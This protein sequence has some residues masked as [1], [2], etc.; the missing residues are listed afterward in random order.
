MDRYYVATDLKGALDLTDG[1]AREKVQGSLQ[2]TEG[3]AMDA[4]TH[5]PKIEYKLLDG[6]VNGPEAS[7]LYL[8][9]IR[10]SKMEPIQKKTLLRV[11]QR[12]GGDWKVTQFS[13][14]D[15]K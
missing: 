3:Q 2:L 8:V 15:S 5:H 13:D 10:P 12:E 7:Y 9:T 6:T 1:L 14:H 4:S 11:R